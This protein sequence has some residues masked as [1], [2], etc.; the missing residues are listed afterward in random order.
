[1]R[2]ALNAL[3]GFLLFTTLALTLTDIQAQTSAA[4]TVEAEKKEALSV[5]EKNEFQ[6]NAQSYLADV[7]QWLARQDASLSGPAAEI[8]KLWDEAQAELRSFQHAPSEA[9]ES[10][11]KSLSSLLERLK[12]LHYRAVSNS[13]AERQKSQAALADK[14]R[15]LRGE[16]SEMAEEG[17]KAAPE[18]K[19]YRNRA[20]QE[21]TKTVS[22]LEKEL[23]ELM[24]TAGDRWV[25]SR[26][27]FEQSLRQ[28]HLEQA[29]RLEGLHSQRSA[30]EEMNPVPESE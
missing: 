8:R 3:F 27:K 28:W 6:R 15:D 11:Q 1:M 12:G 21:A 17:K 19:S 25:A 29:K 5:D 9:W 30:V 20:V 4:G 16:I 18:A 10:G 23:D 22:R 7:Q 14:L 2:Q 26:R 13:P 24:R